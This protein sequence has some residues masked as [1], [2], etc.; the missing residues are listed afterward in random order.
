MPVYVAFLRA[1]N[2][3]GRFVKMDAMRAA[4]EAS[5]FAEVETHIQSGNVRLRS[6]L[7]S[8]ARVEAAMEECL[9]AFAGFS[10]A[11]MVRT[12]QQVRALETEADGTPPLLATEGRRYVA[13]AKGPIDEESQAALESYDSTDERARA[14]S[15]AVLL[16][17]G[18]AFNQS[19]LSGAR[20]ERMAG[21]AL[22]ARDLKVIRAMSEKWG[23]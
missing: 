21:Q 13:V 15:G 1:V 5:G 17:Y 16:E 6:P 4:L 22:T 3:G 19:R 7:R 10:I 12:P 14:I 11:A 2:V 9:A 18:V 23:A 8:P 20:L